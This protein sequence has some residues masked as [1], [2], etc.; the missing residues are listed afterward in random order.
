[1]AE[2]AHLTNNQRHYILHAG[3]GDMIVTGEQVEKIKYVLNLDGR[4][5]EELTAVRNSVVMTLSNASRVARF[6]ENWERFDEINNNMSGIT[7]VIDSM[8]YA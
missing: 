6:V 8:L 2:F 7:A 1:M 4:P 5:R 3:I